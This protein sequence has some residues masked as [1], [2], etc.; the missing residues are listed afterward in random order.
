M[1]RAGEY[2]LGDDIHDVLNPPASSS[3]LKV[4]AA[5]N[6]FT[7]SLAGA[8]EMRTR[9]GIFVRLLGGGEPLLLLHGLMVTGEMFAPLTRLLMNRYHLIIPD[10]RGHGKSSNVPGPYDV[11]HLAEDLGDVLRET[12]HHQ[13]AVL[14]YSHGGAV[15]QQLARSRPD[16]V[17][18]LMLVCTYACNASTIKEHLEAEFLSLLLTFL[19]PK[20]IGKLIIRQSK[21]YAGGDVGLSLDQVRWLRGLIAENDRRPMRAA[22]RGMITFDSRGWL[23]ELRMPTVV[24]A[25]AGDLA[26]PRHHFDTLLKGIHGATGHAI[27]HAG[28]TLMWTHTRELAEIID[29]PERTRLAI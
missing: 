5:M 29:Q 13:V 2:Q 1:L 11:P 20:T 27:D 21:T 9:K 25:G 8:I 15:A 12:G 23:N 19:S 24:I 22:T 18:R 14:G 7:S 16:A 26:V 6:E 10:L 4:A 28:H 17:A 3:L